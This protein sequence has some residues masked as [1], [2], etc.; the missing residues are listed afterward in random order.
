VSGEGPA[1]VI[2]E[3]FKEVEVSWSSADYRFT[4]KGNILYAFMLRYP[5]NLV[6]VLT[7]LLPTEMVRSVRVLGEG[8]VPFEQ[9]PGRLVVTLPSNPPTQYTNCLAIELA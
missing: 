2:I 6:A 9:S 4:K 3:G 7:S 5:A 8:A 1:N